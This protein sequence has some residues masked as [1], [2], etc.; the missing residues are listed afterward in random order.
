MMIG[1]NCLH[2]IQSDTAARL[3]VFLAICG[4]DIWRKVFEIFQLVLLNEA[5][6]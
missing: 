5:D 6:N 2:L 4:E 3:L 1:Y